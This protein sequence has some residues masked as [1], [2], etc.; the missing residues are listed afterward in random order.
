MAIPPEITKT[1]D[2]ID[3][4]IADLQRA[5]AT[6]L[7]AFGSNGNKSPV[8]D[9][10]QM[11]LPPT[12]GPTRKET[13]KGFLLTHGPATRAQISQALPAFP[14]G[15]LSYLLNEKH[16]FRRNGAGLWVVTQEEAQKN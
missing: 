14:V 10:E 15:T 13:L 5:K 2:F 9:G 3:S 7:A 11:V 1:L 16:G 4:K 6:L 8:V 12:T